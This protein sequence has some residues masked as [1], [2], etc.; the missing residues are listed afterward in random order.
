LIKSF[1]IVVLGTAFAAGAF[2][3]RPTET[4]FRAF[5]KEQKTP[6]KR[7]TFH[8]RFLWVQVEDDQGKVQFTGAFAAK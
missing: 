3:S 5:A 7:L 6:A 2:L 1:L 8:D 4:E